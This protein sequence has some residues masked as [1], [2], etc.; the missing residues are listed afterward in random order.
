MFAHTLITLQNNSF[1][2]GILMNTEEN[3]S[4]KDSYRRAGADPGF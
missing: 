2:R 3:P 1:L 4:S